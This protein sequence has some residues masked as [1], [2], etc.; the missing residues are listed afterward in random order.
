MSSRAD[1]YTINTKQ[2]EVYSDLTLNMDLNPITGFLAKVSNE[3]SIKQS[4]KS[5]VLTMRGERFYDKFIGSRVNALKFE[6]MDSVTETSIEHEILE[7][8]QNNEP[9]VNDVSCQITANHDNNSY[10]VIIFFQIINIPNQT[11]SIQL[12][13][14]RVR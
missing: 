11:F 1:R 4:L 12:I 3:D 8:I 14:K 10:T 7:C 9:R 5:I 2:V 13:L 6:P